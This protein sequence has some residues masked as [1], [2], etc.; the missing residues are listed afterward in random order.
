MWQDPT[1]KWNCGIKDNKGECR[2]D[3]MKLK[4]PNIFESWGAVVLEERSRRG[5]MVEDRK[6]TTSNKNKLGRSLQRQFHN[7]CG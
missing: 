7:D 4:H 3:K 1:T 6:K 5:Y 2:S